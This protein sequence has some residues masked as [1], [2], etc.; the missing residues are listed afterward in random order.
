MTFRV[1]LSSP[2]IPATTKCAE[3][4][5]VPIKARE[6]RDY[7]YRNFKL[8]GGIEV[9][10]YI[11]TGLKFQALSGGFLLLFKYHMTDRLLINRLHN[12]LSFRP[13]RA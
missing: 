13:M 3:L 11:E 10:S 6:L 4:K 5:S 1:Q 2:N 8:V 12:P 7:F 9:F